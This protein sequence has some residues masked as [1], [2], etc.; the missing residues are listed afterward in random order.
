MLLARYMKENNLASFKGLKAIICASENLYDWQR[1]YLSEV[2]NTC[3]FSYYGHSEKCALAPECHDSN[4]FEF[5]PQYGYVELINKNGINCT[6]ENERGEIVVTG[7]NNYVSPFI[8]Y[9]TD[10][11][12]IYTTRRGKHPHWF[13]IKKIDGR[14][15]DF[16]ID[17]DNLP[18]TYACISTGHSGIWSIKSMHI[19][20]FRMNQERLF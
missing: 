7:F 3:I 8:R 13:N 5:Y 1:T 12:A 11:M 14:V 20:I 6:S 17:N 15:Q 16:L 4:T 19:N 2:F 10:D 18:K 9:K